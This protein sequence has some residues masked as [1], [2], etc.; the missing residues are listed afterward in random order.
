M[1][2]EYALEILKISEEDF[3][4]KN[5]IKVFDGIA[6][7]AKSTAAAFLLKDTNYARYTSTNKLRKDAENRF[8]GD[9][10][11]IAGGLFNTENGIFFAS[12]KENE[13]ENILIDEALQ[14]DCKL[15]DYVEKMVGKKNVIICTDSKQMLPPTFGS[16]V[17]EKF[18]K[19]CSLDFVKCVNLSHSL[20]AIN[21]E[22]QDMYNKCYKVAEIN[23]TRLF[24]FY[25]DLIPVCDIK[26]IT[27][28]RKN[29]YICHS[30]KI[31]N[32]LYDK[33]RLFDRYEL[34]LIPKGGIASK[35]IEDLDVQKYNIF[36]QKQA[37][38]TGARSYFQ[39]SNV[40]SVTRYQGSEIDDGNK[41]YFFLSN[42][43]CV[44]NR[45]FYTMITRS[46]NINDIFLVYVDVPEKN[47]I[48]SFFGHEIK[49]PT[50]LQVFDDTIIPGEGG[51]TIGEA[52]KKENNKM[53]LNEIFIDRITKEASSKDGIYYTKLTKNGSSIRKNYS[54]NE[55]DDKKKKTSLRS[56]LNKTQGSSFDFM[57]EFL[58]S[59]ENVQYDHAD[60][61]FE[62]QEYSR[63]VDKKFIDKIITPVNFDDR[64]VGGLKTKY[65]AGLDI[66]S[67]YPTAFKYGKICDGHNFIS[68]TEIS[69]ETFW[70]CQN[71]FVGFFFNI[72]HYGSIGMII[73]DTLV[74]TMKEL[75]KDFK[76]LFIGC[77]PILQDP[78]FAN[79][80]YE[81]VYNTKE[82][83]QMI[84]ETI[85]YGFLQKPYLTK[86]YIGETKDNWFYGINI[87]HTYE[88]LMCCVQSEMLNF[89]VQCKNIIFNN[90]QQGRCCV[91]CIYFN[92]ELQTDEVKDKINSIRG[93]FDY[94]IFLNTNDGKTS[95]KPVIYKTYKDL[96][97]RK[98]KKNAKQREKRKYQK[99][100]SI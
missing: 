7:S 36:S 33:Q 93:N 1:N 4:N 54:S 74:K 27:Y 59:F 40:G 56:L 84:K 5:I 3:F 73:T 20:R 43:D 79:Q 10:F 68:Y 17:L 81:K 38:K 94:R 30:N 2:K 11:T 45:E 89:I 57:P 53:E 98:E 66:Y 51:L 99:N 75:D 67:A 25:K 15:F 95:E 34:D 31:E 80:I 71:E 91:D 26:N 6:G 72:S 65:T 49:T 44:F 86:I 42:G 16:S 82:D 48:N 32:F 83:K 100:A 23:D 64:S 55:Y 18:K 12:E 8:G 46:K 60:E 58:Q 76:A 21:K 41:L 29:A 77:S 35:N 88:L 24:D 39:I 9:T 62:A 78:E 37:L 28:S 92:K 69:E 50:T 63:I 13:Y 19:F 90:I 22:S 14:T 87:D 70:K 85:H 97:T 47:N 61:I 96:M 52:L